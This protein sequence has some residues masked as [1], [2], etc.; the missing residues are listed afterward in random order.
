M[1]LCKDCPWRRRSQR[2]NRLG[3]CMAA[4]VPHRT[5]PHRAIVNP[6]FLRQVE[7]VRDCTEWPENRFAHAE[8]L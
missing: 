4:Y 6:H 8:K 7:W 3:D 2:L 5:V 1:R